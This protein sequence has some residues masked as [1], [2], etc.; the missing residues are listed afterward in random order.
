MRSGQVDGCSLMPEKRPVQL[1]MSAAIFTWSS[2]RPIFTE[3]YSRMLAVRPD[4]SFKL[5]PGSEVGSEGGREGGRGRA[6]AFTMA[7]H[8][9]QLNPSFVL[10]LLPSDD[11]SRRRVAMSVGRSVGRVGYSSESVRLDGW[12]GRVG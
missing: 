7:N 12:S 11:P 5:G 10:F 9:P 6:G 1:S 3:L 8:Q 2:Y 4:W